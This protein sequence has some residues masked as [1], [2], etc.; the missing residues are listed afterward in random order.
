MGNRSI[1][2]NPRVSESVGEINEKV[3]FR[4][5]WRAFSPSMLESV[6]CEMFNLSHP[7]DYM[8]IA[9]DV[10]QKWREKFPAVVYK[11]GTTRAHVVKEKTNPQFHALLQA[12]E[13]RTGDGIVLN[14][15]LNRPGEVLICTPED[16][17]NMFHGSDL[18]Y[19][20]M[21]NILVTKKSG[22]EIKGWD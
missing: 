18:E 13:E 1:L 17:L 5:K 14:T 6:A 4:E 8:T 7:A 2:G 19:L 22:D 11:D 20:I 16:A 3:K 10:H 15:S 21:E 9:F 12:M